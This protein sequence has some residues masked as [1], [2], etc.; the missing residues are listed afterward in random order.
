MATAT[1]FFFPD[2]KYGYLPEYFKDNSP[3]RSARSR[4]IL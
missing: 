1:Q 2:F 3:R 4:L